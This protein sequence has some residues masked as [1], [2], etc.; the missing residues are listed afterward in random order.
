MNRALL[1]PVLATLVLSLSGCDDCQAARDD[2]VRAWDD[3][4]AQALDVAAQWGE[5]E[6]KD[7]LR[8]PH[9][10]SDTAARER[11]RWVVS[12]QKA[13]RAREAMAGTNPDF[14]LVI[15]EVSEELKL[16]EPPRF[17]EDWQLRVANA[18]K[19]AYLVQTVCRAPK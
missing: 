6:V 18:K 4:V 7:S 3:V 17:K 2:A 8:G 9:G 5:A 14:I 1:A 16:M 13:R 12:L 11:Q 15:N 10:Q 19:A